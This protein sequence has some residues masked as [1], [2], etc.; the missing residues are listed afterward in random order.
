MA[1]ESIDASSEVREEPLRRDRRGASED[2]AAPA[3]VVD[4]DGT[5]TPTDTF[6]ESLVQLSR[7]SPAS[8]L[9]LPLWLIQGRAAF[10]KAVADLTEIPVE[11]LPYR[12]S[13][14][15]YLRA[16]RAAGRRIILATAANDAVAHAVSA[17]LGLF[18]DV[19]A[20]T[21]RL[22]LK[23]HAKLAACREKVGDRFVY[24]GDSPAD[25]PLWKAA[26][27][28]I[29]V[30]V[31]PGTADAVRSQVPIEKEF[32]REKAAIV[33]WLR[34]LRVH[35][36]LKNL[37]LFVP[38]FTAFLFDDVRLL[39]TMAVAFVAFSFA[40]ST[41]YVVNDIWDLEDDRA[42]PRKRLRPF[43]SGK[44][45]ITHGLL[46]AA[47]LL[48]S[49]LVLASAVSADFLHMVVLYL[50]VTVAYSWILKHY[51]LID[52]LTLS[53]LYT[54]RVLAGSV[55]IG[56]ETSSWLLAFCSFM[57]LSLA[58][59][60]RCSELIAIDLL[61]RAGLQGRDYR[62]SDLSVLR[63]LGLAAALSAV[64][65]FGLFIS[66]P[67]NQARYATPQLL[68]FVAIELTYWL[69]RLWVKISR[70]EVHDDPVVYAVRDR[71]SLLT[72]L[73]IG[74]T[75]MVAHF[76]ALEGIV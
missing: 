54:F 6:L 36:W 44:I 16:E 13:L 17:H 37:L 46:A 52:V 38:L 58:V 5:L 67:E 30:G 68:W 75:A 66:D 24:A 25:I 48:L 74:A 12:E 41:T 33:E 76:I 62:V 21:G 34:A 57:F 19:I 51:V 65:V 20:S 22:N 40:A 9:R 15:A 11:R 63:P 28:A 69:G 70:G 43:A 61:G 47:L 56:I 27:A 64:V 35:Q 23:G 50:G 45:P 72:V 29:L 39:W 31:A 3:I 18:D 10:K 2:T 73:A 8:L 1:V 4:L 49:G 32:P 7:R 60:K 42:H 14:L 53:L 71:T 55:A 59:G 26:Q